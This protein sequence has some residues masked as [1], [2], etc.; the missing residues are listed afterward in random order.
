MKYT[1]EVIALTGANHT[2]LVDTHRFWHL[3]VSDDHG[4][5]P[6]L[7]LGISPLL[8]LKQW[9]TMHAEKE[10]LINTACLIVVPMPI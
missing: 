1:T 6:I 10:I 5:L 2:Q 9:V 8:I 4:L 3:G 7:W